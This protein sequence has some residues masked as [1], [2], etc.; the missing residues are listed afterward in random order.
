LIEI[1]SGTDEI[2]LTYD[3]I[4][5]RENSEIFLLDKI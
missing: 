5:G 1:K 3:G 2:Y 4:D